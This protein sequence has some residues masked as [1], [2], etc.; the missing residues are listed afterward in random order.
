MLPAASLERLARAQHVVAL[1]GAGISAESGVPT[2]R[3]AQTGLW[4]R[5][6]AEQL[7]T[8]A[9]F[10]ASPRL[11]WEWYEWR[12]GLTRRA[13]PNAGHAALV[14]LE[15]VV[16][17][18]TLLTQNV[19]GLHARAGSR[20][21]TELHGNLDTTLCFDEGTVVTDFTDDG[22]TPPRCPRC[23]GLL[24][25]GVVWFGEPLPKAALETAERAA[26]SCDAFLSIGTSS[27]VHPAAGLPLV[28]KRHG[29]LLIEVNPAPTQLTQHADFSLSGPAGQV[30]PELVRQL[31]RI[32]GSAT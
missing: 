30:L 21:V 27:L 20:Q 5:Y 18:L 31:E 15:G 6:S 14:R 10:L 11:V 23:G 2:F 32:L 29:A 22:Q 28:A 3:E 1:T 4:A 16:P 7:A 24:R 17:R 13:L 25:P 19:D 26:A 8:P 12:R 9:A